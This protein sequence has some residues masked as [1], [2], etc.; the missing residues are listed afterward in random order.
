MYINF[1]SEPGKVLIGCDDRALLDSMQAVMDGSKVRNK[2][3]I[4]IPIKSGPKI[5]QFDKSGIQ[6]HSQAVKDE[7][8]KIIANIKKRESNIEKIKAQYGKVITF[9]YVY[10]GVYELLDHQKIMFNAI[11][12][13]DAAAILSD[14]GTC[15]TAPYLWAIDKRIAQGKIKKALIITLPQLKRNVYEEMIV[16]TPHLKG[17]ILDNKAQSEKIIKKSYKKTSQNIDYDVY[18]A[19]YESMFS[20]IDFFDDYYFEMVVLDEAHRIGSPS[21]RQTKSIIDKFENT[22]FKYI[23]SGTLHSNNVT[24]FYMPFR[25]LGPDTVP[26]ANFYEFRRRYMYPVDPD[27]HIWVPSKTAKQEVRDMVGKLSISFLKEDCLDLPEL[28][29]ESAYCSMSSEQSK[30]Y[31]DMA[32]QL[33][34]QI[35]DMCLKCNRKDDCDRSCEETIRAKSALTL[36]GKLRQI[37]SGFYIN[38]KI[39]VDET[40][41]EKNDSNIITFNDNPKIGLLMQILT[42]IPDDK[43]VIIWTNYVYAVKMIHDAISKAYGESVSVTCYGDQDAFEQVEKFKDPRV[44]FMISNPS[45]GGVGLNIQF[46]NYQ[47][48]YSNS[49]SYI[50]REQAIGRQH[51]KGQKN[52]VTVIDLITSKTID[53]T[54]LSALMGKKDLSISLSEYARVVKKLLL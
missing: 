40:G 12:Y 3:Q 50:Q 47:I 44:S 11:F 7:I 30:T 22:K 21:S 45:K 16:Q 31:I 33:I 25:F 43:K 17:V 2:N 42:T 37:A 38:T 51:R 52:K 20:L 53:E 6:W 41:K 4:I 54:I 39:T 28:I 36:I 13:N 27:M 8:D 18:I 29:R 32:S 48:F 34:A 23:V 14:P 9:D 49:Y 10:K 15:K 26:Y 1:H 5:Y 19:N 35:D 46:S 24:S